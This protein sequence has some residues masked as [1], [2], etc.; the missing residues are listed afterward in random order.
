MQRK[1]LI[2]MMLTAVFAAEGCRP[3][4]AKKGPVHV[5]RE[6][7]FVLTR[8]EDGLDAGLGPKK[9]PSSDPEQRKIDDAAA[10][11]A[12]KTKETTD[13]TDRR[14]DT[15]ALGDWLREYRANPFKS[16]PDDRKDGVNPD[17]LYAFEKVRISLRRE[18]KVKWYH[19]VDKGNIDVLFLYESADH[20]DSRSPSHI[21][22]YH[23]TVESK[24]DP[25]SK[26]TDELG[27]PAVF[28]NG[29][30]DF[31]KRDDVALR[32]KE[33][34]IMVCWFYYVK[35]ATKD[36]YRE[37]AA[38]GPYIPSV[39]TRTPPPPAFLA[40]LNPELRK[41]QRD[42]PSFDGFRRYLEKNAPPRLL[43]L[44]DD[45][46]LCVNMNANLRDPNELVACWVTAEPVDRDRNERGH[47]TINANGQTQLLLTAVVNPWIAKNQ[48][49]KK[50]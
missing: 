19:D 10:E 9:K 38:T 49:S 32:V 50:N 3:A 5:E 18:E 13:I 26:K 31:V 7:D 6:S 24:E 45:N 41:E 48:P 36:F 47:V 44:I 28:A 27:H 16:L 35:Y 25:V 23:K 39:L 12:R 34:E 40:G 1:L 29:V 11:Q 22:C 20:V 42:T 4:R 17:T 21:I 2:V 8:D 37:S 46:K 15:Y 33:Q 30:K 43:K 14:K